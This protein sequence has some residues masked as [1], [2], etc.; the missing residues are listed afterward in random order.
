MSDPLAKLGVE[1]AGDLAAKRQQEEKAAAAPKKTSRAAK[2]K[3]KAT[4]EGEAQEGSKQLQDF[5]QLIADGATVAVACEKTGIT[6]GEAE[7]HLADDAE[8]KAQADKNA[9][10]DA[11]A[12]TKADQARE[13][14]KAADL[15]I[16]QTGNAE[17][18]PAAPGEDADTVFERRMDRLT[19]IAGE[20]D[21]ETGTALG[22]LRDVLLDL[23]RHRPK[24]WSAMSA[25]EQ[26][27]MARH[28]EKVAQQVL[29]KVVVSIAQEDMENIQATFLGDFSV[30]GESIQAKI[31]IDHVDGES[32]L[33][34]YALA[35]HKIIIVSADE[36]RF[37]AQRRDV[38]IM[39]D[40]LPMTFADDKPKAPEP[41][42]AAPPADDSDL[43]GVDEGETEKAIVEQVAEQAEAGGEPAVDQEDPP[44]EESAAVKEAEA[45]AAEEADDAM[46]GIF[47]TLAGKWMVDE[48]D[49]DAEWTEDPA[50]AH[51]LSHERATEVAETFDAPG[52][53]VARAIP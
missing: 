5:K 18:V 25:G 47:D 24:L 41:A 15:P 28:V 35:G 11:V 36:K 34:A 49:A 6:A 45:V 13:P 17:T 19:R 29:R 2:A 27:D 10:E 1:F 38:D 44:V 16:A 42:P 30:K 31:K 53:V 51:K 37:A 20:A 23:F 32:L 26:Q 4:M 12:A 43:A 48:D 9:A 21:F 7:L 14:L 33:A 46:F 22:D 50:Q 39:P 3:A 52:E 40:Q 8:L